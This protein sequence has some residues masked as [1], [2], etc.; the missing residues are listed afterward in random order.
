MNNKISLHENK[1]NVISTAADKLI[2][3]IKNS[4]SKNDLTPE[5]AGPHFKTNEESNKKEISVGTIHHETEGTTFS[6]YT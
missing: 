1:I 5:A 3:I 2:T 4:T 6:F